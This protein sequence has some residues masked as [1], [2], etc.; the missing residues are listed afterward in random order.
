MTGVKRFS[1]IGADERVYECGSK[2]GN[3]AGPD[4]DLPIIG[5][6]PAIKKAPRGVPKKPDNEH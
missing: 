2:E 6:R 4:A 1:P 3:Y 5:H